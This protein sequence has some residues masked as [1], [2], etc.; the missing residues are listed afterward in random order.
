MTVVVILLNIIGSG[1]CVGGSEGK[2]WL[3]V[4]GET[5]ETASGANV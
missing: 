3:E 4:K 2:Q 1:D 5:K